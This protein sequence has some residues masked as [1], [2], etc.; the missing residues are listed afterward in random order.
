MADMNSARAIRDRDLLHGPI[1]PKILSFVFPLMLTNM[2][3]SIYSA[4]DMIIV[5]LSNVDGAIGAIGTTGA[6]V[7]MIINIFAGLAI[8]SNVMVAR[9]IGEGNASKVDDAV[10]TSVSVGII[11]GL[12]TMT[13]GLF[14][15][16]PLLK[17]LGDQGHILDLATLYTKIYFLG[18]PFIS[19][20]NF[21]IAIFRAKGDTRTPLVVLTITGLLN[22]MLNLIF[23][24]AFGM[25]VDGV[26]L[27]T[28]ISNL[29]SMV[30]LAVILHRDRGM[31][32][33]ELKKIRIERKSLSGI[34]YNGVPASLQGA[35]F[36]ISNMAIQSSIISIN[37][38][39]FPGGSEIIDGNAAG[40]SI[41][42]FAYVAANSVTQATVTFTSQHYGARSTDRINKVIANCFLVSFMVA[43]L[44]SILLLSLRRI[45]IPLYIS[46]PAAMEAASTRLTV[47]LSAYFILGFMEVGSG[48]VRGMNRSILS[49]LVS[50]LGSCVLRLIWIY[51]YVAAHPSLVLVYISYP[52]S[53]AIT[54]IAHFLVGNHLR[55]KFIRL[56]SPQPSAE[57]TAPSE[58]L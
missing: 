12:I 19:V 14:I 22:V 40:G 41:E 51:T 20:T 56:Y 6:M 36:S 13:I 8:G 48:V 11:S 23:V 10:H 24:K 49:T 35:L 21:L 58:A 18:V 9:S 1:F 4:A 46:S 42:S 17:L 52:V 3:Q 7:A 45:L 37:N 50:L 44:V 29:V 47:M 5:G 26:S 2:L 30:I 54:G 28:G 25:S 55:R 43:E 32:H 15:S 34:I 31:C 33:L 53:W 38:A 27:A 57:P 16:R 39:S